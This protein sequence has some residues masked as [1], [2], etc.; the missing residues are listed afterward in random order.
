MHFL[1]LSKVTDAILNAVFIDDLRF[2]FRVLEIER[3]EFQE[4]NMDHNKVAKEQLIHLLFGVMFF[5]IIGIVAVLLDLLSTWVYQI[6]VSTFTAS[7][8]SLT[9]HSMLVLDLVLFFIYLIVASF[10]LIKRMTK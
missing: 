2:S 6:G 5:L 8:L 10:D 9:A 1:A 4:I 7:A 3:Q